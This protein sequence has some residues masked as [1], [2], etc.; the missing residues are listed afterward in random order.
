MVGA[1]GNTYPAGTAYSTLFPTGVIPT[2]DLNPLAVKL[3]GPVCFPAERTQQ[4][5]HLQPRFADTRRSKHVDGNMKEKDNIWLY[6]LWQRRPS[7]D[8]LPFTGVTLP[9]FPDANKRHFQ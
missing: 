4:H 7:T 9:E 5:L 8:T 2:A 6:G 3:V 1:D